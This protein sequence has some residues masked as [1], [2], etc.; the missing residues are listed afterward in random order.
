MKSIAR[1]GWPYVA[2]VLIAASVWL[3]GLGLMA[4]GLALDHPPWL[5]DGADG[6]TASLPEWN[7]LPPGER[8]TWTAIDGSKMSAIDPWAGDS[9]TA[10]AW[11]T[12][13]AGIGVISCAAVIAY[14]I[15][16]ARLP[17]VDAIGHA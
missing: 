11:T 9:E 1:R 5:R 6:A 16:R 7:W 12:F 4:A 8:S 15:R 17:N 3:A 14:R 2:V 10:W 13:V